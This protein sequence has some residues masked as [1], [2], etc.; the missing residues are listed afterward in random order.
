MRSNI[1][2]ILLLV[3]AAGCANSNSPSSG[4]FFTARVDGTA[5]T[6]DAKVVAAGAS[7]SPAGTY[8]ISMTQSGAAPSTIVLTL[9]NIGQTGTF[10]LGVGATNFGG[11]AQ[12]SDA[13]S[14]W[15]T[16]N[17]GNDG[18]IQI[19]ALTSTRIA[20]SFNFN[21]MPLSGAAS[22]TKQ[23]SSGQF[24]L[25]IAAGG[26]GP[27][28]GQGKSMTATIDGNVWNGAT[29]DGALTNGALIVVATGSS[30][31][32]GTLQMTLNGVCAAAD[33]P[34]SSGVTARTM[35]LSDISGVNVWNS[36]GA[37]GGGTV[38]ISSVTTTQ[39]TGKFTNITLGPVFGSAT[40]TRSLTNGS[41][42]LNVATPPSCS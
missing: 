15:A 23:V 6:A 16:P 38:T 20:G 5:W 3:T 8:T 21:A 22:G 18:M 12:Y 25:T 13:T 39:I 26:A 14:A 1:V 28:S 19:T 31:S 11:R 33:Y 4:S 7:N 37:G 29:V 41:F 36:A 34:L 40:G 42:T 30:N 2:A 10:F 35:T 9:N 17:T 32:I 24:D 27:G